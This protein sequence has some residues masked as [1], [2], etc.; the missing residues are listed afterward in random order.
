MPA[1]SDKEIDDQE[2]DG[3]LDDLVALRHHGS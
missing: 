1:F 2:L 3:L